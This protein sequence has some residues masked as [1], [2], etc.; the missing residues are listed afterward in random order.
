MEAACI[1]DTAEVL[2]AIASVNPAQPRVDR[3]RAG[4]ALRG[5]CEALGLPEPEVRWVDDLRVAR[6]SWWTTWKPVDGG[7][8]R[9]RERWPAFSG[10]EAS[11]TGSLL[12]SRLSM[13]PRLHGASVEPPSLPLVEA[14][15]QLFRLLVGSW[16]TGRSVRLA[17]NVA[18][19]AAFAWRSQERSPSRWLSALGPLVEAI[20]HGLMAYWPG[21]RKVFAVPRPLMLLEGAQLHCWDGRPAIVWETG[22]TLYYWRGVHLLESVGARPDSLTAGR[23]NQT[24]NAER[25]RVMLERFGY[26]RFLNDVGA[27]LVSEDAYGRLWRTGRPFGR[28]NDEPLALVE[29]TNATV[30]PDGSRKTYFLHVPPTMQTARQAVAWSFG[31]ADQRGYTPVAES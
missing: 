4:W 30:E 3:E 20:Q 5:Y 23:I 12:D 21:E 2:A 16:R 13:D 14:E 15:R 9:C 18:L 22:R 27:E 10:R 26:E 1:P 28:N 29:V 24:K 17:T 7:L 11:L 6:E 8:V 25:R 19:R 31:F